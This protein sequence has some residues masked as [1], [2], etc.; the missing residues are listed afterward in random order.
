MTRNVPNLESW[1][2]Q[3]GEARAQGV[4]P[5]VSG[6][7]RAGQALPWRATK[8]ATLQR[9][10]GVQQST[11]GKT[12]QGHTVWGRAVWGIAAAA[13][14]G[15][16][17]VGV[18]RLESLWTTPN[19]PSSVH[20][21]A[22]ASRDVPQAD[23]TGRIDLTGTASITA[24]PEVT[25]KGDFNGDGRVDGEDIQLFLNQQAQKQQGEV[26]NASDF[27]RQLLGS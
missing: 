14:V 11:R 9:S 17:L 26:G 13:C 24:L 5:G 27:A 21:M 10:T 25:L 20:T 16:A 23:V 22:L 6:H 7:A 8:T 4:M 2:K 3:L 12:A 18:W 19:T 15:L 1:L